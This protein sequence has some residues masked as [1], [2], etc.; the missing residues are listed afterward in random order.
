MVYGGSRVTGHVWHECLLC[1]ATIIYN[2]P[3]YHTK[4]EQVD[5]KIVDTCLWYL[6]P[7]GD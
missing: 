5:F 3:L 1:G 2:Y 4:S 6:W 7:A